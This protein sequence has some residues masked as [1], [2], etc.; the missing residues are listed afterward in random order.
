VDAELDV[1]VID[2]EGARVTASRNGDYTLRTAGGSSVPVAF[3]DIPPA[4]ALE[5]PWR[6][7][8]DSVWGETSTQTFDELKSWTEHE[9]VDVRHFS[10]VAR[11]ATEFDVPAAWLGGDA[12][13]FLDLGR[14]WAV[15]EVYLNG[16]SQG[17]LWQPPFRLDIT[18]VAKRGSN[19]LEIEVA[20]TW[21]NRL[22]GDAHLP[23]DQ[24]RTRTNITRSGGK[25][26]KEKALIESGLL[27][28]VRLVPARSRT[29]ILPA[30]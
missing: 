18:E 7:S 29:V 9:R 22:I 14:L 30:D 21:A 13:L 10:G 5:G 15:G 1:E 2:E 16:Q 8:F 27:G 25:A 6:V 11:Y 26:W 3:D 24:R 28:P 4:R 23:A 20:N 17:I 19:V 12:K